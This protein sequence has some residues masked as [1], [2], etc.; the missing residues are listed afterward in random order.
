MGRGVRCR[1]GCLPKGRCR[2]ESMT[3]ASSTGGTAL[4]DEDQLQCPDS[5]FFAPSCGALRL[6]TFEAKDPGRGSILLDFPKSLGRA[7]E[8]F[9]ESAGESGLAG[10]AGRVGD[11]GDR[12]MACPQG[13]NGALQ[14]PLDQI[15]HRSKTDQFLEPL[16]K[17]RSR[18]ADLAGE[19]FDG[20]WM[21]RLLVDQGDRPPDPR[22]S[23]RIE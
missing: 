9:L 7:S 13:N 14:P 21:R 6:R 23:E 5:E 15:G 1:R 2:S 20:P 3:E 18:H 11:F 19:L 16:G 17:A 10:I 4:D 12:A 22:I 8:P